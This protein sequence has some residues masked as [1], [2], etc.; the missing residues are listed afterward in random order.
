MRAGDFIDGV[1]VGH[2][3]EQVHRRD[4]ACFVADHRFDFG[5]VYVE[6]VWL[7]ID[8]HGDR[9]EAHD[10]ADSAEKSVG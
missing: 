9:A 1:H 4:G 5:D 3:A 6:S 8:E 2:L 10:G 7:D